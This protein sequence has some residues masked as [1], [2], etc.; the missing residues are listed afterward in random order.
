M[1]QVG[2]E[3]PRATPAISS[4]RMPRTVRVAVVGTGSSGMQHLR[5][6][7]DAAGIQA[8]AI[9]RRLDRIRDLERAGYAVA[10]DLNEAVGTGAMLCI[11]ATDTGRHE[12]DTLAALECGLHVLVEKPLAV[13]AQAASRLRARAEAVDRQLVV[14]CV[15]RFSESLTRFRERLPEIGRLHSVRIEC[16]S[17]LPEWRPQRPYQQSYS[18]RA[19]EGGALLDLIHEIDYAGWLFGWPASLQARIRNLGRLGIDAEEAAD[20]M[21]EIREGALISVSVDYLTRSSRRWMRASGEQGTLEWDGINGV[22]TFAG[23]GMPLTSVR[24]S[25][26]REAMWLAQARAFVRATCGMSDERLATGEDG[27]NALA[28]CDAARRASDSRAEERVEY[29]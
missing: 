4:T 17:Y 20:L 28:V 14:G 16:Q 2:H 6:L 10:K 23:S 27:V 26:T 24:S 9:P 25:Q 18:A 21:W 15:L 7:R 22:V 13:N 1:S 11:I 3:T 19:R 5:I 8:I 29:P 12:E